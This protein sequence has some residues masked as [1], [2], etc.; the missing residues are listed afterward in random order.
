MS[1]VMEELPSALK[2]AVEFTAW[3]VGDI[4]QQVVPA[5]CC[6]SACLNKD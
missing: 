4:L 3:F 1:K 6:E 2:E 5:P